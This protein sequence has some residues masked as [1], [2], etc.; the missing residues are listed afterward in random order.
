M[1]KRRCTEIVARQPQVIRERSMVEGDYTHLQY[2]GR[3]V[4]KWNRCA[5]HYAVPNDG[6]VARFRRFVRLTSNAA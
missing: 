4:F 6:V 5:K 2:C 3:P 1:D